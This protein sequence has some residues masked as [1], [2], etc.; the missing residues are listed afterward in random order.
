MIK[1][2]IDITEAMKS[3]SKFSKQND[4]NHALDAIILICRKTLM[5]PVEVLNQIMATAKG[6]NQEDNYKMARLILEFVKDDES[7]IKRR[8]ETIQDAANDAILGLNE[9]KKS[10]NPAVIRNY[11]NAVE[12]DLKQIEDAL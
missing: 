11:I 4:I 12:F 5:E 1:A 10:G 3:F 7:R 8:S 6:T 9:I 2:E